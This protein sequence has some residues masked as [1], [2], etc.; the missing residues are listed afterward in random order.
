MRVRFSTPISPSEHLGVGQQVFLDVIEFEHSGL[1][2]QPPRYPYRS[3]V[4]SPAFMR[5]KS[6][7]TR[8]PQYL[9]GA[10]MVECFTACPDDLHVQLPARPTAVVMS[11]WAA[12]ADEMGS[13]VV[14]RVGAM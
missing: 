3:G 7:L 13:F 10:L 2:R 4:E 6:G 14:R 9:H 1:S 5:V 11:R 12:E 8:I